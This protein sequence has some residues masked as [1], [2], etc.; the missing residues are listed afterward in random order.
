MEETKKR[1]YKGITE[2]IAK[3]KIKN[4]DTEKPNL[5]E[6]FQ[7]NQKET[8]LKEKYFIEEEIRYLN[9]LDRDSLSPNGEREKFDMYLNFLKAKQEGETTTGNNNFNSNPFPGI[10]TNEIGYLL[11]D[12]LHAEYK[13][14]MNLLTDYSFIYR[15]MHAEGFIVDHIKPEMFKNWL[16]KEPYSIIID[17]KLKTLDRCKTDTKKTSYA[18]AKE[19][20]ETSKA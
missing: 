3:A 14:S 18:I 2:V 11:F 1:L 5:E 4:I 16:S 20:I 12:R 8:T 10:F 15:M 9:V 13:D 7:E 17:H 6:V 19:L